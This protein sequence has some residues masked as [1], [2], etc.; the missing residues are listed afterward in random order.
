MFVLD[1]VPEEY[2]QGGA[3]DSVVL[4]TAGWAMKFVPLLGRALKDMAL[5]GHSDFALDEFKI[6]R[7][8]IS[9]S[10]DLEYGI[11]DN[12]RQ[13]EAHGNVDI[14]S[15]RSAGGSNSVARKGQ[16]AIGSSVHHVQSVKA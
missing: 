12:H 1:F 13:N 11:I 3:K 4:F 9:K 7:V 2:L 10:G 5:Y 15:V 16:Q 6:E 8:H 14:M